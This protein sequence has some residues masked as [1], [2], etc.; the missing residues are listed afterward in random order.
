MKNTWMI[1]GCSTGIGRSLAEEL[2]R[3]S[4]C[5]VATARNPETLE[6]LKKIASK[7]LLTAKLDI[8]NPNDIAEVVKR[9]MHR[10]GSIE[11]L[12]NNAGYG[13]Y[14]TQE[15]ADLEEV[16]KMFDTNVFGL[17]RVTQAVLP[18]M[19]K[20]GSG[21][22]VNIS[23]LGGRIALPFMGFYHASKH[24]VEGLSE[25]LY[26]ETSNFGIRVIVIEPGGHNTNFSKS[27]VRSSH[28]GNSKSP[29]ASLLSKWQETNKKIISKKS[30]PINVA[31]AIINAVDREMPFQRIQVG[32]DAETL[33]RIR[34]D[35]GNDQI[36]L[37]QMYKIYGLGKEL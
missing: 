3:K 22:V 18:I 13:Y 23:S 36:F 14:G 2:L 27:G 29:Y 5:V 34:E 19:R 21:T 35:A 12:V 32:T 1:T 4:Q 11:V 28:F 17:V 25:S 9:A 30:E 31:N 24:A 6:F 15:E 8:T 7:K 33:I 20:K 10:F 26:F 37:K 16:Q